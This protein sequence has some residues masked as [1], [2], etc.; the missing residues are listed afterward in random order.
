MIKSKLLYLVLA[1]S[2][3]FSACQQQPQ[4]PTVTTQTQSTEAK[5]YYPGKDNNW[6]KKQPEQVGMDAT[7]LQE[8]VAWAKQQETT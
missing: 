7:L 1:L 4:Q 8:A 3:S 5:V 2:L 6:E